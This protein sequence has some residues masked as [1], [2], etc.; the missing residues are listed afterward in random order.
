M[1]RG[2]AIAVAACL[3]TAGVAAAA[4]TPA[5][6]VNT[7]SEIYPNA[8]AHNDYL[9][10]SPLT[11]ALGHGF[12]SIEADVFLDHDD[13]GD[14]TLALCHGMDGEQCQSDVS[15][16]HDGSVNSDI[17]KRFLDQTYL[18][19][20]MNQVTANNGRVYGNYSGHVYLVIEIKCQEKGP[21]GHKVCA[22]PGAPDRTW[23]EIRR[24]LVRYQS[25]YGG[26][27]QLFSTRT[28]TTTQQGAVDIVITG[29]HN[30]DSGSTVGDQLRD[31]SA[32]QIARLDGSLSHPGTAGWN[33]AMIS[34]GWSPGDTCD[35]N[36]NGISGRVKDIVAAHDAGYVTRVYGEPD[37]PHRHDTSSPGVQN[38][39]YEAQQDAWSYLYNQL[40]CALTYLSSDHLQLLPG[41]L[42]QV[43][44]ADGCPGGGSG[45]GTGSG[46]VATS[47]TYTGPATA[48]YHHPFTPTVKLTSSDGPVAGA[49]IRFTLGQSGSCTAVTDSAGTAGC[50]LTPNEAAGQVGLRIRFSGN[51]S[52]GSSDI[53]VPFTITKEKTVLTYTGTPH[54][55]NGT[56][57]HLAAV[58][59]TDDGSAVAGP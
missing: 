10:D 40:H 34:F 9:N 13:A 1:L 26:P 50:R 39:D 44:W 18:A 23:A 3:L 46:P 56:S 55:A 31:P 42:D 48:E 58:L 41:F 36:A 54:L 49:A 28:G 11:G 4:S 20:L 47:L 24:E 16:P 25:A 27:G 35:Y 59:T 7:P 5:A 33:T 52:Y 37:C 57:A 38:A 15:W 51:D 19:P 45:G 53:S 30:D 17:T 6:K 12:T 2:A 29:G 8:H 32:D 43:H 22:D 14:S 21:Q